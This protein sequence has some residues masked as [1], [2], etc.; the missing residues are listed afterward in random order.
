MTDIARIVE[1]PLVDGP[2]AGTAFTAYAAFDL[3]ALGYLEEEYFLSGQAR[4]YEIDGAR[5]S[6]G[7][8]S[9]TPAGSAAYTTRIVVRRPVNPDRFN[10]TVA[11]EWLNVSA[12]TDAEP[13]WACTHRH[14][15]R[16]GFAWVGVSAQKAGI[17]GGGIAA[18]PHLKSVDPDRYTTLRHPGDAF[19]YDIFSQAG[20]VLRDSR[21][22]QPL[23]PLSPARLIAMGES[24]SAA[25]LVT[26]VNAVDPMARAYDGYLIHGRGAAGANLDGFRLT[27]VTA[28]GQ[29][30]PDPA[31]ARAAR[32]RTPE[33]VRDDV[34]VPVLT[35]QSETDVASMGGGLARGPDGE[36]F[37]LWEVAGA[38]HADTYLIKGAARDTGALSADELAA[39]LAPSAGLPGFSTAT[40]I[41]SG[42]QQHYVSQAALAQLDSW[43]RGEAAPP[44]AARLELTADGGAFA[45][46]QHGIALGGV[47]TPWV[48]V[49]VAVLSGLGQEGGAGFTFLFGT[50]RPFSAEQL[51]HLYPGGRVSY[52]EQF[53]ESLDRAVD[54][55][56][57]LE[58]DAAEI[59]SLAAASYPK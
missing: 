49:P 47:R 16:E 58:A 28:A 57:I 6:D 25:F 13:D 30:A 40:P 37:R 18:G 27:P 56:F 45:A 48:D 51:E 33:R 31:A 23:G 4:A 22:R 34:R 2:I 26:Y 1:P 29:P 52:L 14:I 7:R 44:E 54:R 17:D 15:I 32:A 41:N 55:G 10:G 50:T 53:G 8:W 21:G 3:A 11:V 5:G 12:G 36:R 38:A 19:S 39:A 46:D 43:V 59:R 35:L 20:R 24:Q 42:P 9:V